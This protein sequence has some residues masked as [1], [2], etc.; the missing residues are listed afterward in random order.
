[1]EQPSNLSRLLEI[2]GSHKSLIYAFVGAFSDQR[3]H[4]FGAFYYIWKVLQEVLEVAPDFGR[5]QHL[6]YNGWMA[7]LFSVI[8]VLVYIAGLMCSQKGAFRIATNLRLNH[9]TYREAAA[10]LCRALR[11]W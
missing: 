10:W 9:G 3:L 5:A 7:V 6:A 1:M 4:R 8:A 11:Q 2:A